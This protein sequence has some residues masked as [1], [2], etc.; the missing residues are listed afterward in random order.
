MS[1]ILVF[2]LQHSRIHNVFWLYHNPIIIIIII[3]TIIIIIK[4]PKP[5]KIQPKTLIP[6]ASW[7]FP[8]CEGLTGVGILWFPRFIIHQKLQRYHHNPFNK[9]RLDRIRPPALCRCNPSTLR[10]PKLLPPHPDEMRTCDWWQ[11]G[12]RKLSNYRANMTWCIYIYDIWSMIYDILYMI[13]NI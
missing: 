1:V 10:A 11:E 4:C 3:I 12:T 13:Y 2:I 9:H 6:K 8:E 5:Q 7:T